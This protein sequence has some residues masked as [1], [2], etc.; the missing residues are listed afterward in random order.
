MRILLADERAPVRQSLRHALAEVLPNVMFGEAATAQQA[1]DLVRAVRWDL[2][3]VDMDLPPTGGLLAL[4][5][6]RE[7]AEKVPILVSTTSEDEDL[8]TAAFRAGAAG[9]I[10]RDTPSDEVVEAVQRVLAGEKYL[11]RTAAEHL[12]NRLVSDPG[13]RRR[14]TL[15]PRELQVLR[16]R[17]AGKTPRDI[18]ADLQLPEAEI[19][20]L[21]TRATTALV[22]FALRNPEDA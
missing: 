10:T 4:E 12:A 1:L 22:R 17:A 20:R 8:V 11:S 7:A 16:L 14:D 9:Y 5:E 6:M 3:I 18:G 21:A 15:S 19:G 13:V 2:V